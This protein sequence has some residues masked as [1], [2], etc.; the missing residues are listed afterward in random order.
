MERRTASYTT[1]CEARQGSRE[2]AVTSRPERRLAQLMLLSEDG[3]GDRRVPVELLEL[4]GRRC[5]YI[6]TTD[7]KSG[8]A[9]RLDVGDTMLLGEVIGSRSENGKYSGEVHFSQALNSLSDLA[10]LVEGLLSMQRAATEWRSPVP[11][12]RKSA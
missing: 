10:S 2:Q 3:A 8:T 6:S 7:T 1:R 11:L 12:E 4:D 5:R 9:V